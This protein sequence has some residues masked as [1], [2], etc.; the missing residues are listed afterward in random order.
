MKKYYIVLLTVLLSSCTKEFLTKDNLTAT[1]DENF[2]QTETQLQSALSYIIGGL[3]SGAMTAAYTTNSVMSFE[4]TTDNA[5]WTANYLPELNQIALGNTT[6]TFPTSAY[7]AV[8]PLWQTTFLRIRQ[9]NRFLENAGKAYVDAADLQR[10]MLE[11]RAFRAYYHLELFL[12]YG[13]IP[14]VT[15]SYT[16]AESNLKRN[17][18]EEIVNF[19]T[20]EFT[21]CAAGLPLDYA[22][23]GSDIFNRFTKGA[24]LTLK[25]VTYLNAGMPDKAAQAAKEVIDLN[26]YELYKAAVA[27]DSYLN[28]FLYAGEN[29]KERILSCQ[30]A[31]QKD[32]YLR[33]A[34]ASAAGNSNVNPT[35]SM[36]NEYE[37][38]QG[39]TIFELG[40]DSLLIYKKNPN[41]REN[42]DPRLKAT[43]IYP[44]VT[45]YTVIN[46]FAA[47]PNLNAIGVNNSSRTGYW[48]RKYVDLVDRTKPNNGTLD[49]MIYRYADV[50]L[51]YVEGLVESGQWANPDVVKYLNM[52]RSRAGM[53]N[54]N[55]SVY[56]TEAK[57]RELY[58]RERRVEL[59]FEGSRLFDIRRWRIA[60]QV[61]NGVVLGATN[62]TTGETVVVETRKFDLKNWL[63]PIPGQ[64]MLANTNMVQN[65]GY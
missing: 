33:L 15:K 1:T 8:Y 31:T 58:R 36:V 29:N 62:P 4:A 37:T 20:S 21:E 22:K 6:P 2:W 14:I 19:L 48:V 26:Y 23:F 32:V 7:M 56:N 41:Y 52:I 34:P 42:R 9:C 50:L 5:V 12:Y 3:P 44:G 49:F 28:L 27:A 40:A 24:C 46:P 35:A 55:V 30:N 64:E 63:W 13:T 65:P 51:M 10:Y 61:M 47:A 11:V 43:I 45:F 25:A 54:V 39:K 59:A 57:L 38:K 60:D 53:P 17:T 16:P 18:K